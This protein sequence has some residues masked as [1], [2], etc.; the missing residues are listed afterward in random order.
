MYVMLAALVAVPFLSNAV[1]N[2]SMQDW[3]RDEAEE[4]IRRRVQGLPVE[5][6]KNYAAL[7]A[8]EEAGYDV[9]EARGGQ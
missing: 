6:G 3:A 1:P 4:R 9:S 2:N 5:F 8:L 7:R